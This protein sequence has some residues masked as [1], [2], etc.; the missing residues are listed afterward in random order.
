[1]AEG[2]AAWL[3]ELE[4]SGWTCPIRINPNRA[5]ARHVANN[6]QAIATEL[7]ALVGVDEAKLDSHRAVGRADSTGR[8]GD[9]NTAIRGQELREVAL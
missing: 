5:D 8:D 7:S 9:A 4:R 2:N 3:V 1:M 6:L